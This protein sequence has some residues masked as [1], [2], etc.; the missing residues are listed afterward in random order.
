MW[1][2]DGCQIFEL[3]DKSNNAQNDKKRE[4]ASTIHLRVGALQAL[5]EHLRVWIWR[6]QLEHTKVTRSAEGYWAIVKVI[7]KGDFG[8]LPTLA[9]M[10]DNATKPVRL[11]A[12]LAHDEFVSLQGAGQ[13]RE[14]K[15]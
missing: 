6:S 13:T 11:R 1:V 2:L 3:I 14:P 15:L 8:F 4:A 12:R 5:S 7:R 9:G 10:C